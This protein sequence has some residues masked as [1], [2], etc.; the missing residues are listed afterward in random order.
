MTLSLL[1]LSA[2][3]RERAEWERANVPG[4]DFTSGA[5]K[6]ERARMLDDAADRLD[7]ALAAFREQIEKLDRHDL[8][9]NYRCGSAIEEMERADDGEWVRIDDV[10]A[11]ITP[12]PPQEN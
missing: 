5:L 8:V 4:C 9:T 6:M 10:L 12:D 11:L 7:T 3:L 1:H 2:Q